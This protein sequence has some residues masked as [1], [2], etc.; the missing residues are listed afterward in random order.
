MPHSPSHGR[1][2]AGNSASGQPPSPS[3]GELDPRSVLCRP[4]CY[5]L[6]ERKEKS[7][8]T[9]ANRAWGG[10]GQAG[11]ATA[12]R[13]QRC[14]RLGFLERRPRCPGR[15]TGDPSLPSSPRGSGR[16]PLTRRWLLLPAGA[17]GELLATLELLSLGGEK[18]G[19]WR[20]Q[21]PKVSLAGCSAFQQGAK[22]GG[23]ESRPDGVSVPA[24]AHGFGSE[25]EA[26]IEAKAS[27]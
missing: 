1:L 24:S 2:T 20:E 11:D 8:R 4:L 6:P 21:L 5:L 22:P 14:P 26:W 9:E 27:P 18:P 12:K 25:G 7:K 10:A 19:S 3:P 16:S 23:S 17:T 13:G 15:E